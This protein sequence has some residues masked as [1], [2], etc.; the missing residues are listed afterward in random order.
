[1]AFEHLTF[2]EGTLAEIVERYVWNSLEGVEHFPYSYETYTPQN[3]RY[4]KAQKC[5]DICRQ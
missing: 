4:S 1:M 2:K 3:I 5:V